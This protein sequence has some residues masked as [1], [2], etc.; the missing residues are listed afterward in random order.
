MTASMISLETSANEPVVMESTQFRRACDRCHSQKLR[1]QRTGNRS[2]DRCEKAGANCVFSPSRRMRK[3]H[4]NHQEDPTLLS[5]SAISSNPIFV[6]ETLP[7][8][9]LLPFDLDSADWTFPTTDLMECDFE[10]GLYNTFSP[11]FDPSIAPSFPVLDALTLGSSNPFSTTASQEADPSC[12]NYSSMSDPSVSDL[13]LPSHPAPLVTEPQHLPHE[14]WIRQISDLHIKLYQHTAITPPGTS[15]N[16]RTSQYSVTL[17]SLSADDPSQSIAIDQTFTITAEVLETLE[18][19]STPSPGVHQSIEPLDQGTLLLIFSLYLRLLDLYYA[20]FDQ[21]QK[22]LPPHRYRGSPAA[23]SRYPRSTSSSHPPL[24]AER[25]LDGRLPRFPVLKIGE[26]SLQASSSV[27]TLM[28]VQLA[29][30][31][32][33]RVNHMVQTVTRYQD[34]S[35]NAPFQPETNE[36]FMTEGAELNRR[37]D[38]MGDVAELSLKAV[39]NRQEEVMSML[40]TIKR[41]L[42]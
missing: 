14:Q 6:N 22:M 8:D 42:V 17:D 38:G 32:L 10:N 30:Q 39:D 28:T 34:P 41:A 36:Y 2:C 24:C 7:L 29:E 5:T 37:R 11:S 4:Q 15:S 21:L 40:K 35:T 20:T 9:D 1:C 19:V 23:S 31:L 33:G 13:S 27:H 18:L 25:M 12:F 26:F 3:V 16:P